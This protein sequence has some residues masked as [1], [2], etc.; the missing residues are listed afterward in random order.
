MGHPSQDRFSISVARHLEMINRNFLYHTVEEIMESLRSETD[1][2]A[3]V[4]L[5][6]MEA[7]SMQSMKVALKM[8]RKA[9]NL[10]YGETLK[11]EQNV[12]FNMMKDREFE[13]GVQEVLGKPYKMAPKTAEG[14]RLNPGF[15]KEVS[16][17]K[18]DSFFAESKETSSLRYRRRRELVAAH[19]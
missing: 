11:M 2:F 9:K 13:F 18:V 16:A 19:Y 17:D 4:I 7:N 6:R 5:Q 8:I 3:K 14:N 10:C 15:Q 1:P 12:A